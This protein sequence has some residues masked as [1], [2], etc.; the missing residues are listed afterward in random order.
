MPQTLKVSFCLL[1]AHACSVS[2][3]MA[4]MLAS[5]RCMHA[6]MPRL[7][8]TGEK[9]ELEK[10]QKTLD[11]KQ[12]RQQQQQSGAGTTAGV[13]AGVKKKKPIRLRK[14]VRVKVGRLHGTVKWDVALWNVDNTAA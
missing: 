8:C 13:K 7:T 12:Q 5:V 3:C 11:K 1:G 2:P 4:S 14:G 10:R 6:K 9:Q